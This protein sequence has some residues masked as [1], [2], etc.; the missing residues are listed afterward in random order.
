MCKNRTNLIKSSKVF[1]SKR[2]S[3]LLILYLCILNRLHPYVIYHIVKITAF[4]IRRITIRNA[5]YDSS[6]VPSL[7]KLEERQYDINRTLTFLVNSPPFFQSGDETTMPMVRYE[8]AVRVFFWISFGKVVI[9][10]YNN[11]QPVIFFPHLRR[12]RWFIPHVYW[13]AAFFFVMCFG[14]SIDGSFRLRVFS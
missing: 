13:F 5:A 7:N 1:L 3:N 4:S 9:K 8:T 10:W 6:F 11:I 2:W 14:R 12:C